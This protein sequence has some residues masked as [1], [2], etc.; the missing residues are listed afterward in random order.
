M[1]LAEALLLRADLQKRIEQIKN[2]LRNN[3]MVQEG[4][5]PSEEPEDLLREFLSCQNELATIIKRINKTNNTTMYN[6]EWTLSDALVERDILLDN[7]GPLTT[8]SSRI[9]LSYLLGLIGEQ[10]RRDLNLIR[11][12]RNEFAHTSNPISFETE[13]IRNR[14]LELHFDPSEETRTRQKFTRVVLG[15]LAIIHTKI[16]LTEHRKSPADGITDEAKNLF[17]HM[18]ELINGTI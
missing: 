14:C 1:K 12:I 9:E 18:M 3:I 6:E 4:E 16:L 15:V 8:F 2:R 17:N 13:S 11:K 7:N 5:A 10:T